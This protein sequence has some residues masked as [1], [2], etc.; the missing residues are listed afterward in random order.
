MA[1]GMILGIAS[2]ARGQATTGA[3]PVYDPGPTL[4]MIDGTFQYSLFASEMAQTGYS[5]SVTGT[6]N[7]GGTAEYVSKSTVAPVSVFSSGGSLY[8]TQPGVNSSTFQGLTVSQGLVRG[9]GPWGSAIQ[10]AFFLILR[11]QEYTGFPELAVS[12][13]NQSQVG[14]F[15]T[16]PC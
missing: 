5:S 16:K 1:L 8:T 4:P 11:R 12:D 9:A 15:R 2:M 13:C 14:T 3:P 10:R 6:T 7:L